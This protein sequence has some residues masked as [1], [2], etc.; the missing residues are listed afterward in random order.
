MVSR[1]AGRG[2]AGKAVERGNKKKSTCLAADAPATDVARLRRRV[3]AQNKEER[4]RYACSTA[5][6]WFML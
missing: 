4:E 1:G 2:A 5:R 6:H 3:A